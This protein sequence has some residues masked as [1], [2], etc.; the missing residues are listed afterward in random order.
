MPGIGGLLGNGTVG[1]IGRRGARGIVGSVLA[2]ALGL[3]L[4]AGL[5][6]PAAAQPR[7][8]GTERPIGPSPAY[9]G[10][11]HGNII[12]ASNSVVTCQIQPC[13]ENASNASPV[14][15]VKTDPSAPG[16]TASS[17]T[18]N[19]PAGAKVLAARLYWQLNPVSTSG[20]SGNSTKANQVSLK[21]PGASGY[22]RLTA[23]TYDW[24]DALGSGFPTLTAHAG[25]KDVTTLVANAGA[26]SYTVADIQA[27]SGM[28]SNA[29]GSNLGCWGGWSLVVAYEYDPDPLR[30]LQIWDGF[31]RIRGGN[32]PTSA[33]IDLSDIKTVASR[34]PNVKMGITAG[35]G[36]ANI[37]GDYLE[38][39]P[40]AASLQRL[41]MPAPAGIVDDN[42]FSSRID[43]VTTTGA[44]TNITS[45]NPNPVN[46]IGYDAR[47]VD[48]TGKLPPGATNMQVKIGTTG[49]ALYPQVVWLTSDALEPDLQI[50]KANDPPG[51][52]ADNP[53]GYVLKGD[54]VTYTFDVAN[55]RA[56]GSTT[57]LDTATDVVLTDTLPT[58]V[59]YVAGSNPN[60]S[61]AGQ[62][63]TCT[64][65]D[66]APGASTKVGFK[67]TVGASVPDGTKLDNTGVVDFKGKLTGRPQH[68]D[69]NAVRNT[70]TSPGYTLTKKV[71]KAE[72]ILATP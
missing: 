69:S 29:G 39:G 52:T 40:N 1:M 71:D 22:T 33:T 48:I 30:Y 61:A 37:T 49:D 32:R 21:V 9:S 72:A 18:L 63:V 45:R 12:M 27:C 36:D 50:T 55:K 59:T 64:L 14:V 56:D 70:V 4:S 47:T 43:T 3:G 51:N 24:F 53:P 2:A 34:T 6:A 42:A 13:S 31:L 19:V 57:D 23:D 20:V 58:G 15:F 54:Q 8:A 17:A 46:N 66:L 16:N 7:G 25:V 67:V 35:D 60:C 38:V 11:A 62:K 44:G 26:G 41:N 10:L 68:R 5:V 65:P 28:S